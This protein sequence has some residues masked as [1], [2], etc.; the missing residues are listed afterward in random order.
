MTLSWRKW[1]KMP[2]PA[3]VLATIPGRQLRRILSNFI[4]AFMT[5]ISREKCCEFDHA[6]ARRVLQRRESAHCLPG[7]AGLGRGWRRLV[8]LAASGRALP[9]GH[10]FRVLPGAGDSLA[11]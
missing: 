4:G 6:S 8:L 2:S 10:V 5:R 3:A 1:R 7:G 9:P 11:D